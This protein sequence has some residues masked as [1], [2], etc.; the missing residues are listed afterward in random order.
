[1]IMLDTATKVLIFIFLASSM[2]SIGLQVDLPEI[3]AVL[4]MKY[5][6]TRSLLANFVI[7]PVL[8]LL[9]SKL[10]PMPHN[11]ATVF[12]LLACTPGGISAIQFIS[13][14]KDQEVL[15]Y[16][17]SIAFIMAILAIFISPALAMLF[18]A[19]S[20]I[21]LVPYMRAF[22]LL[23]IFLLLPLLLGILVHKKYQ[24]IAPK[25][26]KFMAWLG[27][28]TFFTVIIM[29]L[30]LRQQAI[31]A[32]DIKV[33]MVMLIFI[34]FTMVIGWLLGGP[35]KGT[36]RVLATVSSMRNVA[37]CLAIVMNTF[38][39]ANLEAPL[40]AF[41]SLMIPPNLIFTIYW[42]IR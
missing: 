18:L 7:I 37:L 34:I 35:V 3:L 8:G 28:L 14:T 24:T 27:T 5:L 40:I 29:T 30:A 4:K 38:P 20:K 15:A 23:V 22:W 39:A 41:S 16:A 31:A 2:F 13:K 32:I 1:M 9:L 26:A 6:L 19:K 36:R 21:L 17:G 25:L 42:L 11:I 10:I 33:I 12:I